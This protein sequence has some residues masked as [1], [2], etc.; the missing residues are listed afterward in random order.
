[1][2]SHTHVYINIWM[3]KCI[4]MPNKSLNTQKHKS[5][6]THRHTQTHTHTHNPIRRKLKPC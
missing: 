4:C 2:L 3:R 1:M 6:Q 5:T